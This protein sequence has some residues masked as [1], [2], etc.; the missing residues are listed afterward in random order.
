MA[1]STGDVEFALSNLYQYVSTAIYGCGENLKKL[2]ENI[3]LYAKRAFQYN[4]R[5]SWIALVF[6]HQLAL[7]LMGVDRNCFSPFSIEA[8]EDYF[9]RQCRANHEISIC[10]FICCKKKYLA[11]LMGDLDLAAKMTELSCQEFSSGSTG[12]LVVRLI[13]TFVDGLIGF[14]FARKHL[15]DESKW[16]NLGLNA[17]QMLKKGVKSSDWNFSNKLYLLDAELCFLRGNDEGAMVCYHASIKAAREHRFKHEEGLAEEK[18]GTYCLHK[19]RHGDAIAH[20]KNAKKCYEDWGAH[21]VAQRIDKA[22]TALLPL[23]ERQ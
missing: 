22:M 21:A 10:R 23:I 4:Q 1:I 18:A 12:R 9:F 14:F 6:M 7:D 16:T 20:F 19:R 15:S 5:Q 3:E 17:I 8:T 2:S 11:L 13:S